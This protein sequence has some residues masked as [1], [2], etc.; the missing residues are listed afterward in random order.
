MT[1]DYCSSRAPLRPKKIPGW[2]FAMIDFIQAAASMK[3][4][5]KLL[6]AIFIVSTAGGA[7]FPQ[8]YNSQQETIPFTKPA[9][10]L[11]GV[12]LPEGF[13]AT[14]FASEPQVEQPIGFTTDARG[15]IWV[16]ENA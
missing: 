9:D 7:D 5:M 13:H 11:K 3:A 10:A 8:P 4:L 2:T 6:V 12:H 14:L 1:R 16:A 15:R